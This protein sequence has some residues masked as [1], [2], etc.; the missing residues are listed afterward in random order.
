MLVRF[1]VAASIVLLGVLCG[2]ATPV[3]LAASSPPYYL[4]IG[5]SLSVGIQ[6]DSS[7]TE[8][9]TN[10]GY[11]DDIYAINR[12][13]MPELRL[14]KLG[15]SGE[16]TTTMINGGICPYSLGSQLAQAVEF[17]RT[18]RVVL[19]T[20]DIGADNLDS[21]N[22][23]S[24]GINITCVTQGLQT[25]AAELPIIVATLQQAIDPSTSIVAGNYYDPYLALWVLGPAGQAL[26]VE[27]EKLTAS[28][29]STLEAVYDS[30]R[31]PV[32]DV[33]S[34]FE[35]TSFHPVSP[36]GLPLN[37]LLACEWTWMCAPAPVG[38][39]EHANA[40]GYSVIARAFLKKLA[41]DEPTPGDSTR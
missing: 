9:A 8:V 28:L 14:A 13:N 31:V 1:P 32:A 40:A 35:M 34:A 22:I 18:H 6:P 3:G 26:A 16:T 5:D 2:G 17:V 4:A 27:T 24:T 36:S 15:C 23:G 19:V 7:G 37:V 20:I 30:L 10:Q 12:L 29:N 25:V 21:C 38:P 11:V 41:G 39:N 33:Q